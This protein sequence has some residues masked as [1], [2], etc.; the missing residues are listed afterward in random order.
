[1]DARSSYRE[2]VTRGARPVQL[3]IALYEQSIADLRGA[4]VALEK[5]DVEA[6]TRAINHAIIVIG[7][8]QSSL[9]KERGGKVAAQLERFYN[10]VR[11]GLMEAQF[12]QSVAVLEQQI[13][14]LMLVREAWDEVERMNGVSRH[15]FSAQTAD[16]E[17]VRAVR[18]WNG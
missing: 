11:Q 13:A 3:V 4:I 5:N 1:M 7:H 12:V 8:L 14:H 16:A 18:D 6:R 9:D 2:A 15:A 10:Q 17:Q